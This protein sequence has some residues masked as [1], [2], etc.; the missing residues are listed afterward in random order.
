MSR[1]PISR[2][3]DLQRLRDEGYDIDI[4]AGH[5]IVRDIPYVDAERIIRRGV[6]VSTLD[7]ADD[8]TLKPSTHVVMF[9]GA[10]PCK[11]N[12]VEI[13]EF[14]NSSGVKQLSENLTIHHQFSAKPPGGF[15]D[16]HHKVSTY[17]GIISSEARKIDKNATAQS[18]PILTEEDEEESIF[19]YLDSAA[20]RSGISGWNEKLA[21]HKVAIVGL[22]GTG[23]YILDLIAKAPI[24][25]IHLFDGK[26]FSQHSAFRAPGA[27]S[28]EE[29]ARRPPKVEHYAEIY[30]QMRRGLVPNNFFIDD[31]NVTHLTEMEFVFLSLDH[32]PSR[33][34][35]VEFL[36]EKNI[37]FVDVGM[38]VLAGENGVAGTLRVTTSTYSKN[39]HIFS[40]GKVPFHEGEDEFNDY[41]TNMQVADLNALN[42][43]LAV[44][45]WKK[46]FGFYRNDE[47][48]HFCVYSI[49]GNETINEDRIP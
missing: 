1:R 20:A 29:L 24:R 22:G 44:V 5:L 25:E 16:Y 21:L 39:D 19:L 37:P 41:S 49:A 42:A 8:I 46:L 11:S 36:L 2:S 7:L 34:L 28:R 17:I 30:G 4:V 32:G 13:G 47:N 18:F 48:E 3:P 9:S 40:S 26:R 35:I 38:G 15:R 10:Y 14:K 6:L 33:K 23:A 12:G 27:P 45:R 43:T 31:E